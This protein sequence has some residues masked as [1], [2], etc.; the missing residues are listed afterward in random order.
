MHGAGRAGRCNKCTSP[1]HTPSAHAR[2]QSDTYYADTAAKGKDGAE[3]LGFGFDSSAALQA[4]Y[5]SSAAYCTASSLQNWNCGG[6]CQHVQVNSNKAI[7]TYN[8]QYNLQVYVVEMPDGTPYVSFRG[9]VAT[10][11]KDWILNLNATSP[12]PYPG[13]PNCHVEGGFYKAYNAL[14]PA[15][16]KSLAQL[17]FGPGDTVRITGH[18]LGAA[19]ATLCAYDFSDS[20][21]N[22]A[23]MYTFGQP[24][25]GDFN[26]HSS[27]DSKVTQWRVVHYHDPVPHVP[28]E[29][30]GFHHTATE[31]WYNDDN[32]QYTVCNGSGED[33]SC[34]DSVP[35]YDLF[36]VSQHLHYMG[37]L[38]DGADCVG[39]THSEP[40]D[41][42]R[43]A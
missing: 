41:L 23:S 6:P 17:G 30:M 16:L 32:T 20:G 10:S 39:M 28:P 43:P 42:P 13:C 27:L 9:T 29:F 1:K 14:R 2:L 22:V 15:L 7:V 25:T 33:P 37:I 40:E 5:L 3:G 36:S 38:I 31:V 11:I 34:A 21:W 26:F 12:S 24:R 19:M 35:W 8:S 4:A 18:S